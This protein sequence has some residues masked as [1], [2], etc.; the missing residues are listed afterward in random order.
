MIRSGV[1][2]CEYK[3]EYILNDFTILLAEMRSE[4][5]ASLIRV[6][7]LH[8]KKPISSL[9]IPATQMRFP[10]IPLSLAVLAYDCL[11]FGFVY[12]LGLK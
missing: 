6:L 4:I 5:V 1:L 9:V 11:C 10:S 7:V 3:V 12:S 8:T 2:G